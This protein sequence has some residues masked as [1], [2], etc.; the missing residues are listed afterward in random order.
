MN[1]YDKAKQDVP[2]FADLQ[3][4]PDQVRHWLR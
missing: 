2:K 3:R 4:E 1:D